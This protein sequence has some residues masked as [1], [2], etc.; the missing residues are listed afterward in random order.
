MKRKN[1][2]EDVEEDEIESRPVRRLQKNTKPIERKPRKPKKEPPKPWGKKERYFILL[3]ILLTAG[4]SGV[5]ALSSRNWKLPGLPRIT[6]PSLSAFNFDFF[7]ESTIVIEG[8]SKEKEKADAG[9]ESFYSMTTNLTGV[10]GFYVVRLENGSNYGVNE[11]MEFQAASLIKLPVMAALAR[12]FENGNF[13]PQEKYI[14]KASDKR[15]G[16][17]SLYSKP[18]G[19]SLTLLDLIT[20][21]G[22]E[23]DNTAFNIAKNILGTEKINTMINASGM[24]STSL[25]ENTTTPKDIGSFYERLWNGSIIGEEYK[26]IILDSLTDTIYEKHLAAGI[27][28]VRVAHKYGRE[29]HVVNDAGI[30]FATKP[31]VLVLMS[32]GIIDSEADTIFPQLSKGIFEIESI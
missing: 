8:N 2:E 20:Y 10:Y 17:G 11:N 24:I 21:M 4:G 23:S 16:S 32:E 30:I 28:A 27:G 18:I 7:G 12:E 29:V 5:I 14:L 22:K 1:K 19:F 9:V 26:T 6:M 13:D 15:Q 3:L 25:V 31:F